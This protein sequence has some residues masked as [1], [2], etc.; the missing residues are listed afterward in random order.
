MVGQQKVNHFLV[1]RIT[2]GKG[3]GGVALESD[4][5]EGG[6]VKCGLDSNFGTRVRVS[7]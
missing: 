1:R 6:G 4:G 3:V 5:A 2:T 7:G